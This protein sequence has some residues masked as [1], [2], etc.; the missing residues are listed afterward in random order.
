MHYFINFFLQ[1]STEL[2][3]NPPPQK[4]IL[5]FDSSHFDVLHRQWGALLKFPQFE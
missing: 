1:P 3:S 5:L 2:L 4:T